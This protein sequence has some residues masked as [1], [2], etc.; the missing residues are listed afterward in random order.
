M[1][2]NI[3]YYRCCPIGIRDG[4]FMVVW[5]SLILLENYLLIPLAGLVK[6]YG[7]KA[8]MR[9]LDVWHRLKHQ[10]HIRRFLLSF[11]FYSAD[12]GTDRIVYGGNVL[13]I[14]S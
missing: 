1:V 5:F 10:P 4:G 6:A 7:I 14:R 8:I 12:Y 3:G 13:L 2:W 9:L 11:F